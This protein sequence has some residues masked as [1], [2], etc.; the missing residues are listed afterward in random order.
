M[1]ENELFFVAVVV[2]VIVIVV[3]A[4]TAVI[5]PQQSAFVVL[6]HG[7]D[8]AQVVGLSCWSDVV[9]MGSMDIFL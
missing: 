1:F 4:K 2:A 5:V 6:N 3:L 9:L 7:V 8:V